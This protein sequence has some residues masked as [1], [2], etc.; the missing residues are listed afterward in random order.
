MIKNKNICFDISHREIMKQL[1]NESLLNKDICVSRIVLL[2]LY[3][4]SKIPN[5]NITNMTEFKLFNN[6]NLL[7]NHQRELIKK[8]TVNSIISKFNK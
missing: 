8:C 6:I 1:I 3:E 5:N 7:L 4:I 2:I